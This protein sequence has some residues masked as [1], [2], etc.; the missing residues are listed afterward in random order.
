MRDTIGIDERPEAFLLEVILDHV[1]SAQ[2]ELAERHGSFH[3]VIERHDVQAY[4]AGPQAIGDRVIEYAGHHVAVSQHHALGVSRRS[5]GVVDAEHVLLG[6][7]LRC[8]CTLG[9]GLG[10]REIG[11]QLEQALRSKGGHRLNRGAG[12]IEE[13]AVRKDERSAGV[14]DDEGDLL[15]GQPEVD[16]NEHTAL[17]RC[18]EHQLQ[19][20]GVVAAQDGDPIAVREPQARQVRLIASYVGMELSEGLRLPVVPR[21]DLPG[22]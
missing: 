12:G 15:R 1:A 17:E 8:A 2:E 5:R 4:V 14:G 7:R 19:Q 16:G 18:R 21:G 6:D 3:G 11:V 9:F 13:E 22:V 20:L 10:R